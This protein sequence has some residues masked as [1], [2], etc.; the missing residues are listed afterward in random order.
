VI[1]ARI[2]TLI[3]IHQALKTCELFSELSAEELTLVSGLVRE[4]TVRAGRYIVHEGEEAF[5]LFAVQ[6][7]SVDV[8]KETEEGS[9][10]KITELSDG[11][12]FG[13]VAFFDHPSRSA[14]VIAHNDVKVFELKYKDLEQI[15]DTNPAFGLKIYRAMA[16]SM[17]RK[18]RK[19]TE[20]LAQQSHDH[21]RPERGI[22]LP[23]NL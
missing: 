20:D 12:V 5:S 16:H 22:D 15:A 19:T 8:V 7:G 2:I 6:H 21:D 11:S 3:V 18:L 13:E 23:A 10:P 17:S 1:P 14:G 4:R 9:H